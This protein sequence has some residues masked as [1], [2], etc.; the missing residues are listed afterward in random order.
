MWL[1]EMWGDPDK[2]Y[3]SR[4]GAGTVLPRMLGN[5]PVDIMTVENAVRWLHHMRHAMQEAWAEPLPGAESGRGAVVDSVTLYWRVSGAVCV[6]FDV[7]P[8][9]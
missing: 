2:P 5:P 8:F 6:R 9:V 3:S 1:S 4:Y 7:A